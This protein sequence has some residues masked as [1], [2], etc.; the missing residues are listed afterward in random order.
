MDV[1]FCPSCH[2]TRSPRRQRVPLWIPVALIVAVLGGA[3]LAAAFAPADTR[4]F[5]AR[6]AHV[7]LGKAL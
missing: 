3:S 1:P 7:P 4:D 2:E 6:H 5:A